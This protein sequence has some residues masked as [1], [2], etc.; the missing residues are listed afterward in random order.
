MRDLLTDIL[1]TLA[2]HPLRTALTAFSVGWGVFILVALLGAGVG[3]ERNL[4]YEW[5]DDA[6]NSLFVWR[7]R[8]SKPYQGHASGRRVEFTN[9]DIGKHT[10]ADLMS[11]FCD[12]ILKT[13]GEKLSDEDVESYLE[14]TVQLFS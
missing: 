2:R 12:R 9:R 3:F 6:T 10:N 8:T 1:Q 7:G 5:R 14:K 11:S 13:G 4:E